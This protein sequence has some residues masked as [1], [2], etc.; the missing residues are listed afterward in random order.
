[1]GTRY[2][3]LPSS[4]VIRND[5]PRISSDKHSGKNHGGYQAFLAR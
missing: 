1:M 3:G 4:V 2:I 5:P